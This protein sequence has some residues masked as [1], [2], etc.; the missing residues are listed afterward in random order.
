MASIL[1]LRKQSVTGD[2]VDGATPMAPVLT[3]REFRWVDHPLNLRRTPDGVITDF[4]VSDYVPPVTNIWYV[5]PTSG[6]DATGAVNNRNL[7]MRTLSEALKKADVD[8]IRIINVS[9]DFIARN[10]VGWHNI[11]ATRSVGVIVES[12]R[13]V[14][15]QSASTVPPTWAAHATLPNTYRTAIS[16]ANSAGVTDL[17]TR[18]SHPGINVITNKWAEVL[19]AVAR[20]FRTLKRVANEAA[21]GAEP[22]TYTHNGTELI[23]QAHDS[24]N[25]IGDTFMQPTASSNNGRFPT[26]ANNLTIYTRGIDFVGGRPFYAYVTEAAAPTGCRLVME[27]CTLQ[28]GGLSN[29]LDVQFNL[30]VILYRC[31]AYSNLNDGLNYHCPFAPA[32]AG[33][34]TS[35]NV[36]EI[37]CVAHGNGLTGSTA[38]SDNASTAHEFTNVIRLNCVYPNSADRV[39]A[40]INDVH[41][42]N[43][44]VYVGQAGTVASGKESIAALNNCQMWLDSI[45]APIGLNPRL[46][47]DGTSVVR[48]FNS[49]NLLNTAGYTGSVR[50]Y[51]G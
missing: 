22:G 15:V 24:R 31:G 2:V 11:Q 42:W 12:G 43:I 49:G 18:V 41:S 36:I 16:A 27:D 8:Q 6:N 39:M 4:Q 19:N 13:L 28:G 3:P 26:S 32:D 48:Q 21:V 20:P 38:A 23:V 14:S 17:I 46:A 1:S 10:S 45:A 29:G 51:L 5:D 30:L 25:L 7:P 9:G 44:G 35:P 50:D 33:R 34:L 47:S 40:D 37:E